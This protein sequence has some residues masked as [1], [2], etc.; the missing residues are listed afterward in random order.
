MLQNSKH[1]RIVIVFFVALLLC[2]TSF[3]ATAQDLK[4][5]SL[6]NK[7]QTT[8]SKTYQQ[9]AVGGSS[10]TSFYGFNFPYIYEQ[11]K[12]PRNVGVQGTSGLSVAYSN[13]GPI[14]RVGPT[15][16]LGPA[17]VS[18]PLDLASA[19]ASVSV[20]VYNGTLH[21]LSRSASADS[22]VTFQNIS[23]YKFYSNVTSSK[24]YANF[25]IPEGWYF[26]TISGEGSAHI[27]FSQ[28]IDISGNTET[29]TRYLMP[30]SNATYQAV[31]NG[32]A[33]TLKN[34]YI[35]VN[36]GNGQEAPQIS[37]YIYNGSSESGTPLIR[38]VT[39]SLGY[40]NY[41]GLSSSYSYS[42]RVV[43]SVQS[44]TG[45]DL[46]LTNQ[47]GSFSAGNDISVTLNGRTYWTASVSGPAPAEGY[48]N[49]I[50]LS[51]NIEYKDGAVVLSAPF[52]S[53]SYSI[54]FVNAIVYLNS[55]V[56]WLNT[57]HLYF[58][59]T[60]VFELSGLNPFGMDGIQTQMVRFDNSIVFF[61][62]VNITAVQFSPSAELQM[63]DV[64][65]PWIAGSSYGS[66]FE[67]PFSGDP[68]YASLAG[69]FNNSEFYRFNMTSSNV[70]GTHVT[71]YAHLNN[72]EIIN[73]TI[74]S[75]YLAF[76]HSNIRGL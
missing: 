14:G 52:S 9:E 40:A 24:G 10:S 35:N 7:V 20:L 29:L 25:T 2:L 63:N 59:N 13:L 19:Y 18:N 68:N 72:A 39:N 17:N 69:Y 48:E 73:S 23:L 22:T 44:A 60:T 76:D 51:G 8:G 45:T 65:G 64:Q 43:G 27:S 49:S 70:P 47:S 12:V 15:G 31:G 55:T 67:A 66:I 54:S 38:E 74:E 57:P 50:A 58:Y 61:S 36:F 11:P 56:T 42:Y 6:L 33:G 75:A 53:S 30:S 1:F 37:V 32:P 46:Y 41:S 21:P 28:E 71:G 5:T 26:L 62:S 34:G 16:H 3:A 4:H